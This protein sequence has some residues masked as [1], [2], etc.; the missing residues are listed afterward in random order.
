MWV[1]IQIGCHACRHNNRHPS[2]AL[3]YQ[4]T[5]NLFLFAQGKQKSN[6]QLKEN[7]GSKSHAIEISFS[8]YLFP[9]IW[10]EGGKHIPTLSLSQ[11]D[12]MFMAYQCKWHDASHKNSQ[13]YLT[14]DIW[15]VIQILLQYF[16]KG[17]T[18]FTE[19]QSYIA[20]VLMLK[21]SQ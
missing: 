7:W 17:C 11:L 12:F 1:E 10:L 19:K 15:S 18:I 20:Q 14:H 3:H 21:A 6:S 8:F 5:S 16:R 4:G 2:S 9:S 13:L